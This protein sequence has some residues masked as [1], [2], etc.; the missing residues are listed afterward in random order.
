MAKTFKPGEICPRSGQYEIVGPRGG[1]TG[2]E[3]T[4]VK[5]EPLPPTEKSGQRFIPVDY[6]KHKSDK[7]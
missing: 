5:N 2:V 4:V 6:T 7:N 3:R 1:R